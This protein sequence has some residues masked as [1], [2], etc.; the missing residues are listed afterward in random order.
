M[1]LTESKLRINNMKLTEDKLHSIIREEFVLELAGGSASYD[2]RWNFPVGEKAPD[3]SIENYAHF[4]TENGLN[5]KVKLNG[6]ENETGYTIRIDF[7]TRSMG[8]ELTGEGEPFKILGT[9][10]EAVREA[11]EAHGDITR[12]EISSAGIQRAKLYDKMI[13]RKVSGA[14]QVDKGNGYITY[15]I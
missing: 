7:G 4:K 6:W 3:G 9:V 10:A 12:L 1:K 14:T 8:D 13:K 2:Y 11:V 15:E 5:Y